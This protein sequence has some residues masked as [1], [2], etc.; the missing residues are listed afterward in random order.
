MARVSVLFGISFRI[1]FLFRICARTHSL[2]RVRRVVCAGRC[3]GAMCMSP[4]RSRSKIY[5]GISYVSNTANTP[6]FKIHSVRAHSPRSRPWTVPHIF[7]KYVRSPRTAT[8]VW[9]T[10]PRVHRARGAR[11][12]VYSAHASHSVRFRR[13]PCQLF[14]HAHT[15]RLHDASYLETCMATPVDVHRVVPTS[16]SAGIL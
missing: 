16:L 5:L 3:V 4:R 12:H 1:S 6:F 10:V 13:A 2:D 11:S 15:H 8:G 14:I 7:A 9:G